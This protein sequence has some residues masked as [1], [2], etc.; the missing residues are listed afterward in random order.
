M[1]NDFGPLC[2]GQILV[3]WT[4]WRMVN[5]NDWRHETYTGIV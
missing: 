1:L 3:N 4:Y 5:D 2:L